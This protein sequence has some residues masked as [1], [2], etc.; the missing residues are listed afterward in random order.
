MCALCLIHLYTCLCVCSL[1]CPFFSLRPP[2]PPSPL[3]SLLVSFFKCKGGTNTVCVCVWMDAARE[4]ETPQPPQGSL[5]RGTCPEG[6]QLT[7]QPHFLCFLFFSCPYI[8]PPLGLMCR[9]TVCHSINFARQ[10]FCLKR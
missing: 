5:Y 2:P 10:L 9:V 6:L 7:F 3:L 1:A 8:H 4:E